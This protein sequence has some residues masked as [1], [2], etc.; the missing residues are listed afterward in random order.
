M[1]QKNLLLIF[2]ASSAYL[3]T[4]CTTNE[5]RDR[6]RTLCTPSA[7]L[8]PSIRRSWNARMA[9]PAVTGSII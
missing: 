7:E 9:G 5:S 3:L 1:K 6:L 2:I 4:A 8:Y